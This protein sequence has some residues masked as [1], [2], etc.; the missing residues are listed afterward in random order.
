[1]AVAF[2]LDG[3]V[4]DDFDIPEKPSRTQIS[5]LLEDINAGKSIKY[6]QA[7]YQNVLEVATFTK[8]KNSMVARV[9]NRQLVER[10]YVHTSLADLIQDIYTGTSVKDLKQRYGHHFAA[11]NDLS[12]NHAWTARVDNANRLMERYVLRDAFELARREGH[13]SGGVRVSLPLTQHPSIVNTLANEVAKVYAVQMKTFSKLLEQ[14]PERIKGYDTVIQRAEHAYQMLGELIGVN[15]RLAARTQTTR[16][17][18]TS[19]QIYVPQTQV[20][21]PQREAPSYV[22]HAHG[23]ITLDNIPIVRQPSANSQPTAYVSHQQTQRY[24]LRRF[25][26]AIAGAVACITLAFGFSRASEL[27][28]MTSVFA[29]SEECKDLGGY[30]RSLADDLLMN[31]PEYRRQLSS[32]DSPTLRLPVAE[33]I[34]YCAGVSVENARLQQHTAQISSR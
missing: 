8:N 9:A 32:T 34:T 7:T 17:L 16:A 24:S 12:S 4:D 18:P 1:M 20:L 31:K 22:L 19:E 6:L 28:P 15:P 33:S 3:L 14:R 2:S 10:M 21:P 30:T 11:V 25:G 5:Q 13:Q 27:A 26:A 29:T 23:P